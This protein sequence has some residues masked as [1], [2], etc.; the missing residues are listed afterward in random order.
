MHAWRALAILLFVF[1]AVGVIYAIAHVAPAPRLSRDHEYA[2]ELAPLP[3]RTTDAQGHAG[4]PINVAIVGSGD[5]LRTAMGMAG[6]VV[7]DSLTRASRIAIARSVL[8]NRPD[9]TAPVSPLYLLGRQQ[10]IA[11]EREVGN[12]ARRRHHARF[13]LANGILHDGRAV[14]IGDATFDQRAGLSHR[15]L[16][17]THHIAPNVDQ[18]RDTLMADLIHA[19]QIAQS[20]Q[21]AGMGPRVDAHNAEGDRFDTD[22]K[23]DVAIVAARNRPIAP[24]H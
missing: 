10:D 12:S 3:K 11:F 1:L 14:W 6:W 23:M 19:G 13:W 7:A 18:E 21:V 15:T 17:P 9:S 16:R 2:A 4:D 24:R 8:F 20:F 5:E 22:G